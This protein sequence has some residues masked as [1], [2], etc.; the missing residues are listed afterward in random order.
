MANVLIEHS[1][2]LCCITVLA[3]VFILQQNENLR[4]NI[5]RII[6]LTNTPSPQKSRASFCV[7]VFSPH[8]VH[9]SLHQM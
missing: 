5:I 7:Y 1:P 4:Y 3:A 2:F 6:I 9:V 8:L